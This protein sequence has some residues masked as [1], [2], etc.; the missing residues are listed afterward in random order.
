MTLNSSLDTIT[1]I[2]HDMSVILVASSVLAAGL[3]L[4]VI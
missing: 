1:C 4:G 2:L 3:L